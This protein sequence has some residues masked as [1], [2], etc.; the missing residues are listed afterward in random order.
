[1]SGEEDVLNLVV[2]RDEALV[3]CELLARFTETDR[4]TLIHN[5]EF[6]ALSRLSGQLEKM[7]VEPLGSD[8]EVVID[9]ARTRIAAGFEGLAPSVLADTESGRRV[10]IRLGPEE[11]TLLLSFAETAALTR[12]MLV[13]ADT[14]SGSAVECDALRESCAD[15]LLRVG[16]D[17]S[18]KPT[19]Q[20]R[21]LEG[22]IDKLFV[23]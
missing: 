2:T 11:T 19:P 1:M 12:S 21:L 4:L 10:D 22:L 14:L 13:P 6:V 20:G 5:A 15:L 3:L 9:S 23:E 7:L 16:F 18:Y 17:E 8:Y